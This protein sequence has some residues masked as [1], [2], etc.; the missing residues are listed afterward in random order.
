VRFTRW[1][2]KTPDGDIHPLDA[3]LGLKAHQK[4]APGLFAELAWLAQAMPYRQAA[5]AASPKP[6]AP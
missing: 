6:T 5:E 3:P 4:I 2:V 1:K